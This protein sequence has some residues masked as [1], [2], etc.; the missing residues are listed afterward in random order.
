MTTPPVLDL[1]HQLVAIDSQ[2]PGVGESEIAAFVRDHATGRGLD[3][4]VVETAEGRCNVLVE[5]DAGSGPHLALSGHLDTKPIGDGLSA[6][7]TD[8]LTLTVDGDL[9]YGLGSSDMKGAVA[10]MLLAAERWAERARQGRLSLILTADEEAG[11]VYGAQEL[12]SRGLV[13]AD[14]IV[15]GEPSGVS[16]PWEAL[17]VVSRGICCFEV[18]IRSQ[19]GHSGLSERLP[20]SATVAA[21]RATLALSGFEPSVAKPSSLKSRPTVNAAVRTEGGVFFGVHPGEAS[22]ACDIRTVPGMDR[23]ELDRE[24]RALL[25]DALPDDVT[26]DL[27]Y[28]PGSLGWMESAELDVDNPVLRAAQTACGSVLGRELPLAAYPGGTDA[29]HFIRTAGVPTI[30]ALGPGWLSVAHGPNECVGVG[31]LEQ[32]VDLY[33]ELAR[34]YTGN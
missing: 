20:T 33:E 17:Y 10:A 3:A 26:W 12:S 28:V 22:V 32:A 9:A 16:D 27:R 24:L 1:T 15:I 6:W 18:V 2:N 5:A 13:D 34:E 31:Q 7:R 21:A 11:S 4:R 14:A 23:D 25:A 30:A 19:Q 8:P 29:T